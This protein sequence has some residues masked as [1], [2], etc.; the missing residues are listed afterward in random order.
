MNEYVIKKCLNG[1]GTYFFFKNGKLHRE[2]GPAVL[3]AK[4]REN[5]PQ[6][7]D[8]HLYKEEVLEERQPDNYKTLFFESVEGNGS[9]IV[10]IAAYH[11][12]E[13]EAYREEEFEIIKAKNDL[14]NELNNNPSIIKNK[15]PK[16]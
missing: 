1:E 6:F 10:S 9:R 8:E 3:T 11:Y 16:I 7:G 12:I 13:G 5:L 4:T 14:E 2:A 15:K